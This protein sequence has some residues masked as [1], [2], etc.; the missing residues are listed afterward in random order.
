MSCA[1]RAT[2]DHKTPESN[3]SV[4]EIDDWIR[5]RRVF[6]GD[7]AG[8]TGPGTNVQVS[9][10]DQTGATP[11]TLTFSNISQAGHTNLTTRTSVSPSPS[12]FTLGTPS[13]HYEIT[14]TAH[15]QG[16]MAA[17]GE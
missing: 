11:V 1:S 9:L 12:G 4:A 17:Y 8:Y 7:P 3:K 2:R 6:W 15:V 5:I 14:T 10:A 13:I 16:V